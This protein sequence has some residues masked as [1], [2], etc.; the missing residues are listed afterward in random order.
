M[1]QAAKWFDPVIGVD[2]HLIQPPGPVPPVPVPHPFVGIVFDPVGM[3]VGMAINAAISGIFGGP[4]S[5]PVFINGMPAAN[6]GTQ[7][8]GMPVHIPIGGVFVNPPSN[9]G[10]IITGSKTVHIL[11]CS[12]ARLTS[13]VMT[14][15]DPVNMPTSVVMAVPNGK[16]VLIGGPDSLDVLAAVLSGIRTKWVSEKLHGLLQAK[17][18]SWRSKVIC[19]LTGHPVDVATGR[20]LTGHVDFCLRGPIPFKCE[21]IYYSAS[22]YRGPLGHGW[23][24]SFDQHLT[25]REDAIF[26]RAEDG[27][28][29]EFDYIEEGETTHNPVENLTLERQRDGFIVW[30]SLGMILS[31]ARQRSDGVFRLTAIKDQNGNTLQLRYELDRLVSVTDSRGRVIHFVNDA[32]GRLVALKAPPPTGI[33][34]HVTVARFEYDLAGDLVAAFDAQG[35]AFRYVYRNHLLVKE[36]N[37]NG[38]SFHFAYDE[39]EPHGWCV[40]TWGDGGIY[41][42]KLTYRKTAHITVVENSLGAKT[43]YLCNSAGLVSTVIDPIG[44]KTKYEWDDCC[45]KVVETDPLGRTFKYTY[46]AQ[47]NTTELVDPIGNATRFEYNPHGVGTVLIDPT[48]ARWERIL[49]ARGNLVATVDPLGTR[50][51]YRR[52]S[53]GRITD[54]LLP[55][56][57]DEHYRFVS[58]R[59][60]QETTVYTDSNGCSSEYT[61]DAWERLIRYTDA[62]GREVEYTY[63]LAGKIISMRLPNGALHRSEYDPE[64]NRVREIN[65]DGKVTTF[66]YADMNRL[67]ERVDARGNRVQ[68]EHDTEGR[69]IRVVNESGESYELTRN[70][71]GHVIATTGF[72][73]R[74]CHFRVNQ[75]GEVDA[76]TDSTGRPT[77]FERDGLGR[78]IVKKTSDGETAAFEF[79][80]FG[81]MTSATNAHREI[82]WERDALGRVLR[83]IQG[84]LTVEMAYDP[85]GRRRQRLVQ[86]GQ[87]ASDC[88]YSYDKVDRVTSIA[89]GSQRLSLEWSPEGQLR[90]LEFGGKAKLEQRFDELDR[91]IE[92]QWRL[93]SAKIKLNRAYVYDEESNLIEK[94]DSRRGNSYFEYDETQQ[95]TRAT[96]PEL[97]SLTFAYD[98]NGNLTRAPNGANLEFGPGNRLRSTEELPWQFDSEGNTTFRPDETPGSGWRFEH[99]A[100][101]RLKRCIRRDKRSD[102]EES[103]E[104]GYDAIGRRC[105]KRSGERRTDYYYDGHLLAAERSNESGAAPIVYHFQPDSDFAPL[106]QVRGSSIFLFANDHL[107][108]PQE[109][110][111]DSGQVRWSGSYHPFGKLV[112]EQAPDER[113]RN[114]FRFPGQYFDPETGLCQNGFRYYDSAYGRYTTQDPAGLAGDFNLYAYVRNPLCW[115]DPFGL[116]EM[117]LGRTKYK[118]GTRLR[119]FANETNAQTWTDLG[120][121]RG[122]KGWFPNIKKGIDGADHIHFNLTDLDIDRALKP[123]VIRPNKIEEDEAKNLTNMELQHIRNNWSKFKDKVTFWIKEDGKFKK[124]DKPPFE[125]G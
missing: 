26:L 18:G 41:D 20:V 58:K 31:F 110:I 107:G 70:Q 47:G 89:I 37:R 7:V 96:V 122:D 44:G 34:E 116:Y 3:A 45:R 48:G 101:N 21:R 66:R 120:V 35:K 8:K 115:I 118:D 72:D 124:L 95:L 56:G 23:H 80:G 73:G 82:R 4:F 112:K 38:L 102:Q 51:S 19:F 55:E 43:T 39:Y 27:R 123:V 10:T 28:E 121:T 63:N 109:I 42:H 100:E 54:V 6:T 46:D 113:V 1:S 68:F 75:A 53:T 106:L 14:C 69:L 87:F 52:D 13:M 9:E 30:A 74:R 114:P 59:A 61:R 92:Q 97:G 103:V 64:G 25:V 32:L 117:A 125:C 71:A 76:V 15:N 78:V 105:C 99:N 111:D 104:F 77:T 5:G 12:A 2:I 60:G 16:P 94:Q 29:I 79:D 36:T 84:D 93:T 40:R 65:G 91:L 22:T 17:P 50:I 67:V 85:V 33:G 90:G 81:R 24:H 62:L 86:T 119:D 11:G 57:R 49:D 83:E 88:K 98:A 108:V